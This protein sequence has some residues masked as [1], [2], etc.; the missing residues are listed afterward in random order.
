MAVTNVVSERTI[1]S[2]FLSGY[3]IFQYEG[4]IDAVGH[5]ASGTYIDGHSELF[6]ATCSYVYETNC[7]CCGDDGPPYYNCNTCNF[8]RLDF[9]NGLASSSFGSSPTKG[10][11][12][13]ATNKGFKSFAVIGDYGYDGLTSIDTCTDCSARNES[14]EFATYNTNFGRTTHAGVKASDGSLW[15]WGYNGY[16]CLGNGTSGNGTRSPVQLGSY[17][18]KMVSGAYSNDGF[19][20]SFCAIRSD[21]RLW[22][23]GSN[24]S[25]QLG[26]G[27]TTYRSS[28][29]QVAGGDYWKFVSCG[30]GFALGI[31]TDNSLWA[32]GRNQY[33]MLGDNSTTYRSSPVQVAGGG[34]WRFIRAGVNNAYG[35]KKNG[36]MFAW[37]YNNNYAVGDGTSTSRSS[38][39]QIGSAYSDWR[40]VSENSYLRGT[41]AIRSNGELWGWGT[42]PA[43]LS[44]GAYVS[45]IQI[46]SATNHA[47]GSSGVVF[48]YTIYGNTN[49]A[50]F[51]TKD[52]NLIA[53]QQ[54]NSTQTTI[55][56]GGSATEFIRHYNY[57]NF[58]AYPPAWLKKDVR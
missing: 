25:G 11:Y 52:G 7:G 55:Y 41:Y 50:M 16:G 4:V 53:Y 37:G 45:P 40:D 6:A 51:V 38:P 13:S 54:F 15:T 3:T 57:G 18:W 12:D 33:G 21:G 14:T 44:S 28:P 34:S 43:G 29:V 49:S 8:Y 17:S 36:Q 20:G 56:G 1:S 2:K 9:N 19:N 26:D 39:V 22:C 47:S 27:T 31:K 35:I 46:G 30:L 5:R 32:W 58:S 42:F 24:Q 10:Y 48:D 23:W